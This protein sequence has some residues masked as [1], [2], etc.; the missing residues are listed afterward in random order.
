MFCTLICVMLD[1]APSMLGL[2]YSLYLKR[3]LHNFRKKKDSSQANPAL[4][5]RNVVEMIL[6]LRYVSLCRTLIECLLWV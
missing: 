5:L 1:T 6:V 3:Y 2:P 4:S